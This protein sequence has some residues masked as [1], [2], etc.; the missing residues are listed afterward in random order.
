[1][2]EPAVQAK[3]P[4]AED[5]RR[6][7]YALTGHHLDGG[8]LALTYSLLGI[9]PPQDSRGEAE[10]RPDATAPGAVLDLDLPAR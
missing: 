9:E 1:V 6:R 4:S 5:V 10:P 2:D 3:P 8:Y 7:Y